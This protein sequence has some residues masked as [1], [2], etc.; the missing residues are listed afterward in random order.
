[1]TVFNILNRDRK[2]Q[3]LFKVEL[4]QAKKPVK[5]YEGHPI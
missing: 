5:K 1:M 2:S 3:P 4:A